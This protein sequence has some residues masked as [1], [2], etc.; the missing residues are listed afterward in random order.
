MDKMEGKVN[1]QH[2]TA[3]TIYTSLILTYRT[4]LHLPG[5]ARP[6]HQG[7]ET[8][9]QLPCATCKLDDLNFPETNSKV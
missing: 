9:K 1:R 4:F 6:F 8:H 7:Q 2:P 3:L 5:I